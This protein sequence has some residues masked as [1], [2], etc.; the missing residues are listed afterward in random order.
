MLRDKIKHTKRYQEIINAFL[1]NGFSHFL[2]RL[3]LTERDIRVRPTDEEWDINRQNIGVRLRQ[4]LQELGPTF[5]KFGQIASTRRDLIPPE[6]TRELEKLQDHVEPFPFNQVRI[7]IES[8]LNDTLEN[9]FADFDDEPLAAGSIGQ[10]HLASLPTGE[11]LAVKVQRPDIQSTIETDLAILDELARFLEENTAW[12]K[13]YRV[14]QMV[15]EVARSLREELDYTIEGRNGERIAKQFIDQPHIYIPKTYRE[16]T[17]K[18]VLAMERIEGIKVTQVERLAKEGYDRE[19]IAE[20]LVDSMFHQVLDHGFFHGDPHAGNVYILPNNVISYIDFG[21]VGRL[22]EEMK[23]HLASLIIHLRKGNSKGMIKTFADM[24]IL[25]VETDI[26][27]LE[28]DLDDLQWNYYDTSFEQLNLGEVLVELFAV[29][30]RHHIRIPS[31]ITLLGKAILSLENNISSLVPNFNMMRAV[32]PFGEKLLLE[33]YSPVRLAK[34]SWHQLVENVDILFH[35]PRDVK[36]VTQTI[37]RGKLQLDINVQQVKVIL[38]RFDQISNRLSF[39]IILLA[40]SILMVGLIIGSAIAGQKE[41]LWQLPV[42]EAGSIIAT[43]MFL[44]LIISIFRS[45][46][47]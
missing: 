46:R 47:M 9:L 37:Q 32:E 25:S 45:G 10:V 2:F 21:M 19:L 5:I 30:Y 22:G 28:R 15:R 11:P 20:R 38:R 23:Y 17:T 26:G 35:L 33:R 14:R 1:R 4:V 12:A 31:D 43:L 27:E 41:L 36:E 40:F 8:E 7:I 13:P 24:G 42:I 16:M 44:Y 29:A 6:I 39:S 3:G 18:K 34:K